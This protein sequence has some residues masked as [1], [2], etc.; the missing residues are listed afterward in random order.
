MVLPV[1]LLAVAVVAGVVRIGAGELGCQEAA[2]QVARAAARGEPSATALGIGRA[3]AP[4]GA[5][6]SLSRVGDL[7]RVEVSGEVWLSMVGGPAVRVSGS[8]VALAE[9]AGNEVAP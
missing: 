6:V 1:V 3:A 2:G 7:V 8:A 4:R 9:D 5:K